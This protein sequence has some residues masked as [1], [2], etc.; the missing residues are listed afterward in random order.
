[1]TLKDKVDQNMNMLKIGAAIDDIFE[2]LR[3]CNKYIPI[4]G[5]RILTFLG[6]YYSSSIS[7]TL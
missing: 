1:M 4:Y 2:V 7:N 5:C 6:G 3:K